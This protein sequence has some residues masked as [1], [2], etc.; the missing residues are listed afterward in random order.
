MTEQ[1]LNR[2]R[3]EAAEREWVN[4][5]EEIQ[6]DEKISELSNVDQEK[7]GI[8][9]LKIE[10]ISRSLKSAEWTDVAIENIKKEFEK[11][12]KEHG[13]NGDI[14]LSNNEEL[15][16]AEGKFRALQLKQVRDELKQSQTKENNTLTNNSTQNVVV[17][18]KTSIFK[19]LF[20][21]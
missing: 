7:K 12:Y 11:F 10:E 13:T 5:L 3:G 2:A 1:F 18:K 17:E 4:G 16:Q 20:G 15:I 14:H 19:R 6:E 9:D 8:I 21:G